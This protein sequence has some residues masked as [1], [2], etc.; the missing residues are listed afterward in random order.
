LEKGTDVVVQI[1]YHP[2]GKVEKDQSSLGLR[3]SGPPTKGVATMLMLNTNFYIPAGAT[4][5]WV[6]ASLTMPR[7]GDLFAISPHA[8]YLGKEMKVNAHLPDGTVKPLIYIK[9]WDFNWQ[10]QYRFKEPIHLPEGARIEMEYSYDNS[11]AN[12]QNP[13]NPP[14][15]VKWGEQTTDEMALAFVGV[16]LPTPADVLP[17]Q[18]AV[19][20]QTLESMLTGLRSFDDLPSEIPPAQAQALRL[21]LGLL[22]RNKNGRL[23]EDEIGAVRRLVE[24]IVPAR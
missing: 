13:S 17:F 22:D 8:H 10:G 14:K 5:Y 16:L 15:A 9:D 18:R 23:D 6:K 20:R 1:H 19:Q 3:F 12:P 2:S 4:D 7:E 24:S 21:A 11:A